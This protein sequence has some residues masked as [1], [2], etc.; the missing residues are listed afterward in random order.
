MSLENLRAHGYFVEI[1]SMNPSTRIVSLVSNVY[2]TDYDPE[3]CCEDVLRVSPADS[4]FDENSRCVGCSNHAGMPN[5][6]K[7]GCVECPLCGDW[8]KPRAMRI[9]ESRATFKILEDGRAIYW[10]DSKH[11]SP[12]KSEH[13][14]SEIESSLTSI[15]L[16]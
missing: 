5:Q 9:R 10:G 1:L 12:M 16:F 8:T 3:A 6:Y 13:M 14:I 2:V 11:G 7:N 4:I 15:K